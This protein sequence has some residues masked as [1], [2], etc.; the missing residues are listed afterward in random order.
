MGRSSPSVWL[1]S[2]W[3]PRRRVPFYTVWEWNTR[4]GA[5]EIHKKQQSQW[6]Y[7]TDR[8]LQQHSYLYYPRLCTSDLV[9]SV[10]FA[11]HSLP[12]L[13]DWQA[14]ISSR[15]VR[16]SRLINCGHSRRPRPGTRRRP[17]VSRAPP[18]AP[19]SCP[20]AQ[21]PSRPPRSACR[22]RAELLGRSDRT[23]LQGNASED[24]LAQGHG[25][26]HRGGVRTAGG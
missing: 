15:G 10:F 3:T 16:A 4:R 6:I 1:A 8:F 23:G 26:R 21:R 12:T 17:P 2:R 5:S 19:R 13:E 25:R 18:R 22:S 14:F 9:A 7:K 11:P 24:S 20:G